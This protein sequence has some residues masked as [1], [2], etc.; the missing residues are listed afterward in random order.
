MSTVVSDERAFNDVDRLMR[1]RPLSHTD[2]AIA[3]Q[4]IE[5]MN[6]ETRARLR[7]RRPAVVFSTSTLD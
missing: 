6:R 2:A 4:S 3:R 7:A 5:Q 1:Q